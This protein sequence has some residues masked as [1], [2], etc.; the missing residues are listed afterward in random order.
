MSSKKSIV[1]L[2]T[3]RILIYIMNS[4]EKTYT[5]SELK[6]NV[7]EAYYIE[8]A[9]REMVRVKSLQEITP[10]TSVDGQVFD[11]GY[12][13]TSF[14]ISKMLSEFKDMVLTSIVNGLLDE[15]TV[16]ELS[17]EGRF[18]KISLHYIIESLEKLC[19][20]KLIKRIQ[21]EAGVIISEK[22]VKYAITEEIIKLRE[23]RVRKISQPFVPVPDYKEE[24]TKT[25]VVYDQNGVERDVI[26]PT[27]K[28]RMRKEILQILLCASIFI[29]VGIIVI[30]VIS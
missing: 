4:P 17:K 15:Y 12:K 22:D 10:S 20:E 26:L 2:T 5:F 3:R 19:Q 8:A 7:K 18:Q 29:V 9:L 16:G 23:A 6:S 24:R 21:P 25:V 11:K 13:I 28:K 30:V 14:G 27:T 1:R